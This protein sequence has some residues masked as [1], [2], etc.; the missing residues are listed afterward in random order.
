[1]K[2]LHLN[3]KGV[4]VGVVSA[5]NLRA[6]TELIN[7]K[8]DALE[9]K[10]K[11]PYNSADVLIIDDNQLLG[12]LTRRF[13]EKLRVV[14]SEPNDT[15]RHLTTELCEQSFEA[16]ERIAEGRTYALVL[17]DYHLGEDD[18]DGK[19]VVHLMR[20]AG[21]DHAI[22]II[23]ADHTFIEPVKAVEL[24][25]TGV[26]G[27]IFRNASMVASELQR[28][29]SVLAFRNITSF[30]ETG[31]DA[32]VQMEESYVA[33]EPKTPRDESEVTLSD[34]ASD[35]PETP[36]TPQPPQRP[37]TPRTPQSP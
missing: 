32:K 18:L 24:M 25:N 7:L 17:V 11:K 34:G 37:Q 23:T 30:T 36:Q 22:C 14:G 4:K 29:L 28:Y 21:Y 12:T 26:D 19:Q 15:G 31:G 1:M 13:C 27:I 8:N 33:S 10:R 16:I 35:R 5:D 9:S 6:F 2:T 3:K 20:R